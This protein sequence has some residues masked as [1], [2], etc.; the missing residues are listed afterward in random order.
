MESWNWCP[1]VIDY[2]HCTAMPCNSSVLLS[3]FWI[4]FLCYIC[5]FTYIFTKLTFTI[6]EQINLTTF[7]IMEQMTDK[8][9]CTENSNA[10]LN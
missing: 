9:S 5:I 8:I 2:Y 10:R 4:I 3:G 7:T 6:M 1:H